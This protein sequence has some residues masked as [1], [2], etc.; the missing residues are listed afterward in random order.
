MEEPV[1]E[2]VSFRRFTVGDAAACVVAS[3]HI[4]MAN[5]SEITA[6]GSTRRAVSRQA[7]WRE[8]ETGP[9]KGANGGRN[10]GVGRWCAVLDLNQ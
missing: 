5:R 8:G 1:T 6:A 4:K 9:A 2:Y 7:A 3:K 10:H